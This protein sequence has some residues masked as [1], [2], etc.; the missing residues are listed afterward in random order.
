MSVSDLSRLSCFKVKV[1]FIEVLL[2][3][4]VNFMENC[5]IGVN[6]CV[7]SGVHCVK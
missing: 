7:N 6:N 5:Y 3:S 1:N 4:F 2:G